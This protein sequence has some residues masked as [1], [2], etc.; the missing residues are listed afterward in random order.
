VIEAYTVEEALNQ[1]IMLIN[2]DGIE[3]ESRA[4]DIIEVPYPVATVYKTPWQRVL[5]N[6][7][8]NA[9]PFFHFFEALWILAGRKDVKFLT[10]FNKRMANFSDDGVTFNA[11]YGSRMR[12]VCGTDQIHTAICILK[13]K[14]ESRQV[15]LQIW[16]KFDLENETTKDK[17]CNLCVL[18][19]I[20][21]G[22]LDITVYNRSND[23]LWGAYGANVVQFSMLQEYVAASVNIPMGTYTQVSNSFHVY[24]GGAG[25][26]LWEKMKHGISMEHPVYHC[27]HYSTL[28]QPNEMVWFNN[29]LDAFFRDYDEF[30]LGGVMNM[31]GAISCQSD[32]FKELVYPMLQMY[33]VY[34]SNGPSITLPMLSA[35]QADD[36]RI[37]VHNWLENRV[38]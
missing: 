6:K 36:W 35:I 19:R 27:E 2:T 13:K 7:D 9:N 14:P 38:K 31:N 10:E 5:V 17:P 32:Y 29:D 8:R 15:V 1:G 16:D 11:P 28:M 23:M 26:K 25:G 21:Q 20:R 24:L 3:Q 22:R 37:G 33:L 34:K 12:T 30:G 4:G 18:F